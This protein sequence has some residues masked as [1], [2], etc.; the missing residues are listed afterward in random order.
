MAASTYQYFAIA[1]LSADLIDDLGVTRTQLG[2]IATANTVTG[3][4][5][6]PRLGS[7][8]DK[9]GAR[10]SIVT[11]CGISS[12][13]LVLTALAPNLPTL[14]AASVMCGL[15]QGWGNPATNKLI[16]EQLAPDARGV[17]AGFKQSGVQFANFLAGLTLPAMAALS[18]WRVATGAYGLVALAAALG[19]L[20][21]ST[22]T[23]FATSAAT[24]EPGERRRGYDPFVV[25]VAIYAGLFGLV[26]GGV[27][28]F[29]P[30]FAQEQL[31]FSSQR[32]GLVV[33]LGGALGIF[34]RIG[35]GRLT[36]TAIQPRR[37]LFVIGLASTATIGSLIVAQAVGSW[38]LW[39]FTIVSAFCLGAW[40]VVAMLAVIRG[41]P[42]GDAGRST[43]I[44]MFGF[45]GGL[46]LGAPIT[47]WLT[48]QTGDYQ[49]A[50]W[51]WLVVALAGTVTMAERKS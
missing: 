17:I 26:G 15:P 40:N 50:W 7:I 30:L 37:G 45:L 44:V 14:L 25:R 8:T 48:D 41:V 51:V 19:A 35:W 49:A 31:G 38:V 28:R 22:D 4:L 33:A 46:S 16:S 24:M 23:E 10:N 18:N 29:I 43:G 5:M 20:R 32:A 11:L 34:A 1:I 2:L 36:E 12:I 42:S 21:L 47:G 13:G 39:L 27:F 9:L 3:A 6:A